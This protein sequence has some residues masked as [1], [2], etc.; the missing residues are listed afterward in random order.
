[1]IGLLIVVVILLRPDGI[2]GEERKISQK[3]P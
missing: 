2:M 1:M 3:I